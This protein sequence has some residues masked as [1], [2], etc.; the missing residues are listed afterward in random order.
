M[1]YLE[2][3]KLQARAEQKALVKDL[4]DASA[5]LMTVVGKHP[6]VSG[7]AIRQVLKGD[8]FWAKSVPDSW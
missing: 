7:F 6:S 3:E 1:I 4:N 8:A 2:I 5:R